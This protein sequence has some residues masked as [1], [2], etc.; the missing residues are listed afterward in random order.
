MR[1]RG[2]SLRLGWDGLNDA[3][4]LIVKPSWQLLLYIAFG[5]TRR[6]GNEPDPR[7]YIN[8]GL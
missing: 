4:L 5:S 3:L 7:D 8:T 2:T 1:R 6:A